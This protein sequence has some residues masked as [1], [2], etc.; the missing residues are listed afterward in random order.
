VFDKFPSIA[1]LFPTQ[2]D[3]EMKWRCTVLVTNIEGNYANYM[4]GGA[5]YYGH[6]HFVS[7][8]VD[9]TGMCWFH[10]GL[11]SDS[12]FLKVGKLSN[13]TDSDMMSV[14]GRRLCMLTMICM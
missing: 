6:N 2:T 10:N 5:I 9:Q 11:C 3:I 7:R 13:I 14:E 12:C 4:L 8:I 1:F